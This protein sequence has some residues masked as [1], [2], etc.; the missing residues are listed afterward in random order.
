[1]YKKK[2]KYVY[3]AL[4]YLNLLRD[5]TKSLD[6][7]I[8][9]RLGILNGS[10]NVDEA[11]LKNAGDLIVKLVRE[12]RSKEQERLLAFIES[13]ESMNEALAQKR[14]TEELN[15]NRFVPTTAY[16]DPELQQLLISLN[17][18]GA[19]RLYFLFFEMVLLALDA[20]CAIKADRSAS[21]YKQR[22]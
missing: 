19:L 3:P 2:F 12:N 8:E 5:S 1:V 6:C 22:M 11:E 20:Y 10:I 7:L 21:A 16:I 4:L 9:M 13:Y 15:R 14:F 17:S 18:R